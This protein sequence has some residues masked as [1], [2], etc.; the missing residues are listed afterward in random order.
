MKKI[1]II[2]VGLMGGSL[3]LTLKRLNGK[4]KRQYEILGIGRN[5][6]KLQRARKLN[7][8]DKFSVDISSVGESDIVFICSPV[9]TIVNIYKTVS[10]FVK[11]GAVVADMG[12]IKDNIVKEISVLRKK[13]KSLPEFVGCHP[14]AG[15]EHSG[16]DYAEAG[17]YKNAVT[18]ITSNKNA[19]GTKAVAKVWKDAGCKVVYMS[20][21]EHDKY[22]AFT[23]HLPHIIAFVYYKI[24]KDKS[25][26]D[27]NIKNLIAGSF[28]SITRVAKS[29]PEMWIPIFLNNKKN[30]KVLSQQFCNEIKNF[31]ISFNDTRKLK[32]FLA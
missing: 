15:T 21:K 1:A 30:L 9:D 32:K 10:K 6:K 19:K 3:G 26:K 5:G 18:V 29:L 31:T 11:K 23:S 25:L 17:L 4:N 16:V 13:N 20:S 8:I 27:K 7:A 22:A 14:M 12:S 2:G 28:N 24:F